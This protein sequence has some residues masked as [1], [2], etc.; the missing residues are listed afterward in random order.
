[1]GI[2]ILIVVIVIGVLVY[3]SHKEKQ[4][5]L[6]SQIQREREEKE[7]R[8]TE[9]AK[10]K[11]ETEKAKRIIETENF[12]KLYDYINNENLKFKKMG[13]SPLV[14]E[15]YPYNSISITETGI[16]GMYWEIV[17]GGKFNADIKWAHIEFKD[18]GISNINNDEIGAF[19][20]A[21]GLKDGYIYKDGK[22]SID[23]DYWGAP[24]SISD[25]EAIYNDNY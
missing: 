17:P 18:I 23:K 14:Y 2:F 4:Q 10:K 24:R 5:R 21:L 22:I 16:I 9:E 8:E 19:A 12:K 15:C 25:I 6:E 3:I 13:N 20:C 11:I 1:M 7:R